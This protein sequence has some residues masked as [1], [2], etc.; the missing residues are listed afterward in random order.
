MTSLIGKRVRNWRNE[1]GVVV[2]VAM[3]PEPTDP[4]RWYLLV[5]TADGELQSWGAS[6]TT[7]V[8]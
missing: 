6:G 4:D 2:A 1:P 3:S 8:K 7:V 5:K